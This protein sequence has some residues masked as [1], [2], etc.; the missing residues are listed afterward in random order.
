MNARG[1]SV[2]P[3]G[4]ARRRRRAGL[5]LLEVT[6]ATAIVGVLLVASL[7]TLGAFVRSSRPDAASTAGG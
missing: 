4:R 2:S 6:V 7:E 5:S 1:L 3:N